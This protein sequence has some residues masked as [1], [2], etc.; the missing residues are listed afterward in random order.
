MINS[1]MNP[2]HIALYGTSQVQGA[3]VSVIWEIASVF[4]KC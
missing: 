2:R 4:A 1:L 3:I